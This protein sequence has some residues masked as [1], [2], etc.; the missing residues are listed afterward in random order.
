VWRGVGGE[1]RAWALPALLLPALAAAVP[2]DARITIAPGTE[3]ILKS[4]IPV[5]AVVSDPPGLVVAERLPGGEVLVTASAERRGDAVVLAAGATR[6]YAWDVCVGEPP[7][8]ACTRET[9]PEQA[10]SACP[11]VARATEDGSPV[12]QATVKDA[13]CLD[14]LLAALAHAAVPPAALRLTLEED[15]FLTMARRVS[16]AISGDPRT[17]GLRAGFSGATLRLEG[18]A[19]R[20]ARALALLA[21]WRQV[22]GVLSVEDRTQPAGPPLDGGP[23]AARA[24]P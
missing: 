20:E 13:R 22:P 5:D 14:A 16:Q 24:V 3:R 7:G 12:V 6:V 17:K 11:D 2:P 10:R 23:A 1:G 9:K 21:A 15:A 4:P 19:G 8:T 18:R